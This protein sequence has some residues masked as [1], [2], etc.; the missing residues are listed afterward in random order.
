[1]NFCASCIRIQ[2]LRFAGIGHH[3]SLI[4][5]SW[6]FCTVTWVHICLITFLKQF[7]KVCIPCHVWPL[8]LLP[9][10]SWLYRSVFSSGSDL[11]NFRKKLPILPVC[12][13]SL[14][15]FQDQLMMRESYLVTV[16]LG[17]WTALCV[18][19][20]AS[21]FPGICW[22]YSKLPLGRL[23]FCF[24]IFVF[25][26]GILILL[27]LLLIN[28]AAFDCSDVKQLPLVIFSESLGQGVWGREQGAGNRGQGCLFP[29]KWVL[30]WESNDWFC[31]GCSRQLPDG[32]NQ[33]ND[34]IM[35]LLGGLQNKANL[36]IPGAAG[37]PNY[38]YWGFF[39]FFFL[40][41][42]WSWEQ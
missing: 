21:T 11:M 17:V 7:C 42:L 20:E 10:L 6:C 36:P 4:Y 16:A 39:F 40:T 19:L 22:R 8:G 1:M 33:E 14:Q 38:W 5:Y 24:I 18:F 41:L 37:L 29:A 13:L 25:I 15:N 12:L 30:S 9:A 23:L 35:R 26:F 2:I 32:W 28:E 27:L 3:T 31:I 34:L